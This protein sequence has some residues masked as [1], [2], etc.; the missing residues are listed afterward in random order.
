MRIRSVVPEKIDVEVDLSE[1][2]AILLHQPNSIRKLW[3]A[4]MLR[5]VEL[6]SQR[7]NL[8]NLNQQQ[9]QQ[10]K[11]TTTTTTT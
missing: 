7:L 11:S 10:L 2:P 4:F 1:K 3:Y 8:N 6:V 5:L 9:Q